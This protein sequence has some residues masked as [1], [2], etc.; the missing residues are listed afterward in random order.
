MRY[1]YIKLF[2]IMLAAGF[3][4][5]PAFAITETQSGAIATADASGILDNSINNKGLVE[6]KNAVQQTDG[7][8]VIGDDTTL[9]AQTPATTMAETNL[10]QLPLQPLI[11][12]K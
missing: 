10:Q 8:V 4:C 2:S 9:A 1:F 7:E 5:A 3:I 6:G 11:E 12:N